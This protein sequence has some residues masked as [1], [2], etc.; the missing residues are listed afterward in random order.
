[1]CHAA[2]KRARVARDAQ[3]KAATPEKRPAVNKVVQH[4]VLNGMPTLA[5]ANPAA[6]IIVTILTAMTA[7][8]F[9]NTAPPLSTRAR[10][11]VA[12]DAE[13][14]PPAAPPRISRHS[15]LPEFAKPYADEAKKFAKHAWL[16]E[17]GRADRD[18]DEGRT[19]GAPSFLACSP[20]LA[21]WPRPHKQICRD[22][23]FAPTPIPI[24]LG[25]V[26]RVG[27][28]LNITCKHT[29]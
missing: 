29:T 9:W 26:N 15:R 5:A 4:A 17:S 6:A 19:A 16:I 11:F 27:S 12:V 14:P 25:G 13:Q 18:G 23:G 10:A 20:A 3:E 21:L 8:Q 2:S 1:M 24:P 7:V 28:V 22:R